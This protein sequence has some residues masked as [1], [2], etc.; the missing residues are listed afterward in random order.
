MDKREAR[1]VANAIARTVVG[2]A[3][4][5]D[6]LE[7]RCRAARIDPDDLSVDDC[8]R[9]EAALGDILGLRGLRVD[10]DEVDAILRRAAGKEET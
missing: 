10:T 2:C 4:V 7:S 9:I 1:K 5:Y 8:V 3:A 6:E